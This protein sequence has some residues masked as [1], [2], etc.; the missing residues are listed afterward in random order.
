MITLLS[1]DLITSVRRWPRWL[2][3]AL[4]GWWGVAAIER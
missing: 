2:L 4:H 1:S 3:R